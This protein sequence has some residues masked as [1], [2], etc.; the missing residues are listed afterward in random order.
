MKLTRVHRI[1]T[2]IQKAW[3]APFINYNTDMR[4]KA[5]SKFQIKAWKAYSN[6]TFGKTM[7]NLRRRRNV[8]CTRERDIF[9]KLVQSPLFH[10]FEI[11][12]HDLVA[13]ERTKA[14]ITFNRPAYTG[15]VIL[16]I[17][18]EIIIRS[19][20]IYD[21]MKDLHAYFDTSDYPE[22]HFLYSI[23]N[24][25]TCKGLYTAVLQIN[26]GWIRLTPKPVAVA[27]PQR[28]DPDRT[29][30]L[31]FHV[32]P[33]ISTAGL[34]FAED[35]RRFSRL[36]TSP[37]LRTA[38]VNSVARSVGGDST[39]DNGLQL[40]NIFRPEQAARIKFNRTTPSPPAISAR[41]A[42]TTTNYIIS[43]SQQLPG[44]MN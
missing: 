41:A 5:D 9:R 29:A 24:K 19:H 42:S 34:Y 6:S 16:D 25:K 32:T 35:M 23:E 30:S 18:K 3:L 21:D 26:G 17:S 12:D 40:H 43:L 15:Q 4:K 2:F 20:D 38:V 33:Q 8:R 22:D 14:T 11:F 44:A 39:S 13:V 28:L 7:E 36:L 27:A 1:V 31:E 10:S 37:T